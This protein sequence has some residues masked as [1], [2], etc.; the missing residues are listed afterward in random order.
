MNNSNT[1]SI[2]IKFHNWQSRV[3]AELIDYSGVGID[4]IED[5]DYWSMWDDGLTPYQAMREI[6]A[7]LDPNDELNPDYEF[8]PDRIED[9]DYP[10]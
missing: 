1:E 3:D 7:I 4:D 9:Q 2:S 8:G 10:D 6:M 5:Q